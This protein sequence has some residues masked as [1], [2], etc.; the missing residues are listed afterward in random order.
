[1]L[2]YHVCMHDGVGGCVYV[3]VRVCFVWMGVGFVLVCDVCVYTMVTCMVLACICV[4][5]MSVLCVMRVSVC[6]L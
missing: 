4:V 3:Y 5:V 6:C 2:V 1:M